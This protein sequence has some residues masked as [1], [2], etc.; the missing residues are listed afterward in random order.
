MC[1]PTE[2]SLVIP[3][4]NEDQCLPQVLT[5][6][7]AELAKLG[8]EYE[9]ILVDDGSTDRSEAIARRHAASHPS[10]IVV[11]LSQ[12]CGQSA[13]F[14][15]GFA[16]ASGQVVVTMDADGQNPPSEIGRLLEQMTGDVDVVVGYRERR[17]DSLWRRWQSAVANRVRNAV[18]GD[19]IRDTGCSLK[20]F[21]RHHLTELPKFTGMH[22]FL[23]TLVR[24]AGARRIVQLPV[25]HRPRLAGKTHYGV[26]DR[27]LRGLADLL[28]IRW[29]QKRWI[30]YEVVNHD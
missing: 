16:H 21:R 9:L 24:L 3:F 4:Y 23:P 10:T 25:S 5:E 30:K 7:E 20:A 12:N 11:R 22:R 26:R 6:L 2:L 27:A 18:T 28:A 14:A 29:L 15:A 19:V 13:A 17:A 8:R 1:K